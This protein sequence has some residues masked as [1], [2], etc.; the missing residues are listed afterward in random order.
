MWDEMR[1]PYRTKRMND[2]M[3]TE[4]LVAWRHCN[5]ILE[6]NDVMLISF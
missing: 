5:V 6:S 1:S 3:L 4:D 2:G